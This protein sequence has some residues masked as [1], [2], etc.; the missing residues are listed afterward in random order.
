MNPF[1]FVTPELAP[2]TPG[3]AGVVVRELADRMTG[4]GRRV[5]VIGYGLRPHAT[6]P[7]PFEVEW[8]DVDGGVDAG[9]RSAAVAATLRGLRARGILPSAVEFVDFDAP[10]FDL[11][12]DRAAHG[13]QE[14]PV[15][16]RFHGPVDLMTEAMGVV[17]PGLDLVATR[18]REVFRMA[19]AVLVPGA[20][21]GK[22]IRDRYG[23]ESEGRVVVAPPPV[24]ELDPV[25]L[26]PAVDP[27]IVVLGR[28]GEVKGSHDILAALIPLL[29]A[30]PG[31][32]MRF[33]GD[34]GWSASAGLPMT[35]WLGQM[36]PGPL[37]DRVRF[38]G[39]VDRLE[40]PRALRSAW[41]VVVPSRFESFCLA[42]HEARR[43]GH[44]L[45]LRDLPAF[46]GVFDEARG[47]LVCDGSPEG[48]RAAVER[49]VDDHGLRRRLGEAPAP[50][51]GDPLAPYLGPWPPPR[52]PH[53]QAG[54]ATAAV[55]R[56]ERA[57]TA[58]G[59]PGPVVLVARAALR[60]VPEPVAK[61]AVR[62]VP[63]ALK[64]RFRDLASWPAEAARRERRLR[65]EDVER[66]IRGGEFS[67]L[68]APAV[69]VVIPCFD[70]GRFLEDALVSV[71]RQTRSDFEVVVVD[72]GSTDAGTKEALDRL[73]WPRVRVIH[74]PNRGLPAARNAGIAVAR[75]R[76]V[77]PLDAD[78]E[79][80][81]G[82]LERM[83]EALDSDPRAAYAHCWAELFGDVSYVW[84]TRPFNAYGEL[85][86]NSVVGCVALRRAAW[87]AV[88][89]YD[90]TMLEGNEDWELWIRLMAGGWGQVQ[91]REPLFRYRK[92]GVSMSVETESR[93]E[94]GVAAIRAR[95][96]DL[97][98][99]EML[100]RWKR[101]HYPALTM[102]GQ[103]VEAPSDEVEV[104]SEKAPLETL[105]SRAK[106]K[107]VS[108]VD[109][110]QAA[111]AA[112][113]G[114]RRLE[115]D[116][117]LAAVGSGPTWVWRRWA[118]LD[119]SAP[120]RRPADGGPLGAVGL[121]DWAVPEDPGGLG[122]PVMRQPPELPGFLEV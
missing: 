65:L 120:L 20:G 96:P 34:D 68:G 67:E 14:V 91:V 87:E 54:L 23:L 43:L 36:V 7:L 44:P 110:T 75:G 37:R 21:I 107:Y 22:L 66:R 18:E 102:I 29:S 64:D 76:F 116:P 85:V 24:P 38:E 45:V 80:R 63:G 2:L 73:D 13:L 100:A 11:L 25:R 92:H 72:D 4:A 78:D 93:Y 83:L 10:G 31:L 119:P 16:V 9:A 61:L 19:D 60:V 26:V 56:V 51:V 111:S 77:V 122:L 15:V 84:A 105:V 52:H 39:R 40:L 97:F 108:V 90:E 46:A 88:G 89:G 79:L 70:Q 86:S 57:R 50:P 1:V 5:L 27:E 109:D 103:G 55:Q 101:E 82:F 42:A 17:P 117:D 48:W 28:L 98:A 62:L 53:S 32:T 71:F 33:V 35:E 104:V 81:P 94:A 106:G 114:T 49:L 6:E 59:R 3:G 8:L 58:A 115:L 41:M 99:G 47:A 95:H 112:L 12:I 113:E 30:R 121:S 74:Q 69:T 118:L